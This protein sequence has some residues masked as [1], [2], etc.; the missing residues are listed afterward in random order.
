[1][2]SLLV[3]ADFDWLDAPQLV[4]VLN[5]ES[6]RGNGSYG[7]AYDKG[8]MHRHGGLYGFLLTKRG[9]TLAPAYDMNPTVNDCQ[10]ILV[11]ASSNRAD[12]RLLLDA[13]DDY[14]LKKSVATDIIAEVV[15]AVK[16]WRQTAVS[17]GIAPRECALFEGRLGAKSL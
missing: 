4:G 1:M 5:Y 8:W 10:S 17:L 16:D 3:Y 7:F 9:W 2:Q 13:S 6:L 12:L 11:T 15:S 14:M